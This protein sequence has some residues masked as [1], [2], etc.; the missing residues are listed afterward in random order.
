MAHRDQLKAVSRTVFLGNLDDRVTEHNI[1]ELA[2]Q[3]T[4]YSRCGNCQTE[5]S[6]ATHTQC[7]TPQ[8]GPVKSVKL[9]GKDAPGSRKKP[10]AFLRY[11]DLVGP[12]NVCVF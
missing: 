3:V 2:C 4:F 5:R 12:C 10:Y 6:L 1:Y 9:C 8:A 11:D 7:C